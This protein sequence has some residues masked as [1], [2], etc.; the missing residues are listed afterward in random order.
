MGAKLACHNY[1]VEARCID[2]WA[3]YSSLFGVYKYERESYH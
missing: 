2:K 3:K 1:E